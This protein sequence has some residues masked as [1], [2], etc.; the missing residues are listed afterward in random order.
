MPK[1]TLQLKFE[2]FD[3][4]NPHVYKLFKK[5]A[6]DAIRRGHTK[7]S[8]WFITNIIRWEEGIGT[9]GGEFKISNDFIALYTRKFVDEFPKHADFFTLKRMKRV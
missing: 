8:G 9:D 2:E 7:M 5:Y 3:K 6:K 4:N 1:S